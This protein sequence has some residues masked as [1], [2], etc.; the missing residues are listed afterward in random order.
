MTKYEWSGHFGWNELKFLLLYSA[1]VIDDW[2][3]ARE[4]YE[5]AETAKKKLGIDSPV[6]FAKVSI[7]MGKYSR[8]YHE[9]GY[10]PLFERRLMPKEKWNRRGKRP[11]LYRLTV[12]GKRRLLKL[13]EEHTSRPEG[14]RGKLL[15]S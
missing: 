1:S 12:N 9:K 2:A 6:D 10:K 13:L 8:E 4:I 14:R 3:T 5:V 7:C 11:Y 15:I